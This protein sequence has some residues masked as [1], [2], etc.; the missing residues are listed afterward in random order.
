MN[1]K[2]LQYTARI[3]MKSQNVAHTLNFIL[4]SN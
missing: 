1:M 3:N 2:L 4:N